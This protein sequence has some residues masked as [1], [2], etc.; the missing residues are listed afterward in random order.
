MGYG[1]YSHDAHEA[2]LRGRVNIPAQQVFIIGKSP[3]VLA[4][5]WFKLPLI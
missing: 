5:S 3:L 4:D 1:D 2:L